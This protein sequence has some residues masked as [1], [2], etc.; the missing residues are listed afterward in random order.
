MVFS[1]NKH[2]HTVMLNTAPQQHTT[3]MN[4]SADAD[5]TAPSVN[6]TL[7]VVRGRQCGSG[8]MAVARHA[9]LAQLAELLL[10]QHH[11]GSQFCD[12]ARL[13]STVDRCRASVDGCVL[14]HSSRGR[15]LRDGGGW[16]G[17]GRDRGGWDGGGR[18]FSRGFRL[19]SRG[20]RWCLID[21]HLGVLHGV[22]E[23]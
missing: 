1:K 2:T 5:L 22:E 21:G 18:E 16:D 17:R 23:V 12:Q 19:H 10:E 6:L 4:N 20:R 7:G 3:V 13:V 15:H 9:L 8:R 14:D 11:L